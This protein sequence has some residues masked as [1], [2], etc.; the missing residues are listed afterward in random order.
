M[1]RLKTGKKPAGEKNRKDLPVVP[2][3]PR[4]HSQPQQGTQRR[5]CLSSVFAGEA[6]SGYQTAQLAG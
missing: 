5:P 1:A 4:L 2:V 6:P 3:Q